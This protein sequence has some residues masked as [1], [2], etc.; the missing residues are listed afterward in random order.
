[1]QYLGYPPIYVQGP[2]VG[3]PQLPP[4]CSWTVMPT[5]PSSAHRQSVPAA[6]EFFMAGS[7]PP[8]FLPMHPAPFDMAPYRDTGAENYQPPAARRH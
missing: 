1:M 4:G 5:P 2:Q 6:G 8:Q 3:L 7:P